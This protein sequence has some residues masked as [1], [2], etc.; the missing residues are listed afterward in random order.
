MVLITSDCGL[1]QW[2]QNTTGVAT[3]PMWA[4]SD[5][6]DADS[7]PPVANQVPPRPHTAALPMESPY[8]AAAVSSRPAAG[9]RPTKTKGGRNER[10]QF[11]RGL[12]ILFAAAGRVRRRRPHS[13]TPYG[14]SL[15]RL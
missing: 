14:E 11:R 9:G 8:C 1:M 12:E 7:L 4:A 10:R 13:R 5:G 2:E 15:L 6:L 3:I